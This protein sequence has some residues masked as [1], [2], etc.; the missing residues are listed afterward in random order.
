MNESGLKPEDSLTPK[1]SLFLSVKQPQV[2]INAMLM[3][4]NEAQQ[5]PSARKRRGVGRW[6]VVSEPGWNLPVWH[7]TTSF[8]FFFVVDFVIH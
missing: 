8:F 2:I 6:A 3:E 1:P 7:D 4:G 5:L